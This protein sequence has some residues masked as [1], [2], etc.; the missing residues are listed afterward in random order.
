[1]VVAG[2]SPPTTERENR[3]PDLTEI[4]SMVRLLRLHEEADKAGGTLRVAVELGL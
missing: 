4:R 2:T 3:C 1:M